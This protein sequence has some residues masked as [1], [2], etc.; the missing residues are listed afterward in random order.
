MTEVGDINIYTTLNVN[1]ILISL[2]EIPSRNFF[3]MTEISAANIW[4]IS[5]NSE[6]RDVEISTISQKFLDGNIQN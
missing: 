1:N 3:H 5:E 6:N 2:L 4:E